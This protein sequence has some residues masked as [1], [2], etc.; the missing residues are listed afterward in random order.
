[1]SEYMI[2]RILD[3]S[4]TWQAQTGFGAC[5]ILAYGIV[6]GLCEWHRRYR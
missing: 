3:L 6:I 1:M 5:A 4:G 2:E